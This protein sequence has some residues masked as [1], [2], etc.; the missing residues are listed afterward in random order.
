MKYDVGLTGWLRAKF[1]R[2]CGFVVSCFK[3]CSVLSLSYSGNKNRVF[4]E[5]PES[6]KESLAAKEALRE[7]TAG[8]FG[9]DLG[10]ADK[11]EKDTAESRKV[12][13]T[14]ADLLFFLAPV[15]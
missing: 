10:K 14:Y 15:K 6:V 8:A 1:H 11:S 4:G 9:Q 7:A 13:D 2:S 5:V 3:S 12:S